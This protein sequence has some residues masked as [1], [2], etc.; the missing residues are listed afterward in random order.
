MA[1]TQAGNDGLMINDWGTLVPTEE[2]L[3]DGVLLDRAH[4]RWIFCGSKTKLDKKNARIAATDAA[5]T[6]DDAKQVAV[7]SRPG[8]SWLAWKSS[9]QSCG[10]RIGVRMET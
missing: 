6:A 5:V 4:R 8:V 10:R 7:R 2:A 9:F 1:V 3:V